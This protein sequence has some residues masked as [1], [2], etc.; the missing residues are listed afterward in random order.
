[1]GT[2]DGLAHVAQCEPATRR[3]RPSAQPATGC[4]RPGRW[5]VLRTDGSWRRLSGRT[6]TAGFHTAEHARR[7][8][9]LNGGYRPG[10]RWRLPVLPEWR[11][12]IAISAGRPGSGRRRRGTWR[13]HPGPASGRHHPAASVRPDAG[14]SQPVAG[15]PKTFRRLLIML[16]RQLFERESST[17]TYL[18]ADAGQAVLIDPVKEKLE[19]YLRLLGELDLKLVLALDTHTHADHITALGELRSATGCRS[20]FGSQ[21][22]SACASFT[23]AEGE[24]LAF[25]GRELLAWHTPGHTD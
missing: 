22:G 10:F 9:H 16:F 13:Q 11:T 6:G 20:G 17:Y 25:G 1:P 3:Q 19:D 15:R 8:C 24:R 2:V 14:G 12:P 18:L 21:S 4:H 7:N 5:P 23:F